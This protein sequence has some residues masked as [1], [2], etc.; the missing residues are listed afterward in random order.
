MSHRGP[1]ANW[2]PIQE[3]CWR[4]SSDALR[5]SRNPAWTCLQT[6]GGPR[7]ASADVNL[8]AQLDP[9]TRGEGTFGVGVEP[10]TGR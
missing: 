4:E 5:G 2:L 9:G 1:E 10:S 8:G 6:E 7:P 3:R